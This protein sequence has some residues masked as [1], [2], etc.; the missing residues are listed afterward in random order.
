MALLSER[1]TLTQNLTY[2]AL[3]AAVNVVFSLLAAFFPFGALF[4]MI[5]LPAASAIVTYF[6]KPKF[7]VIYIV[8]AIA[9]SLLVT[10][11]DFQNTLFYT[12][13]AII[14]GSLY[15]FLKRIK[16]TTGENIFLCALLGVGF[17]YLAILLIQ[18]FYQ[19]DMIAFLLQMIGAKGDL[20]LLIVPAAIL[21]Y[22]LMQKSL[23]NLFIQVVSETFRIENKYTEI[24]EKLYPGF[25][26]FLFLLV[27]IFGFFFPEG[28][29]FCLV[30]GLYWT[31]FAI[32]FL[33]PRKTKWFYAIDG[34]LAV[35]GLILFYVFYLRLDVA[36]RLLLLALPFAGFALSAVLTNLWLLKKG[37]TSKMN[38]QGNDE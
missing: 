31:T 23:A 7:Y 10:L 38:P 15:G 5:F 6:C 11:W 8:G 22:N 9:L 3:M 16:L 36:T 34:G 24:H 33:Y 20:A 19:V 21:V 17:S 14:T 35:V 26:L 30:G 25:A 37:A 2:M 27:L 1:K 4:L 18:L 28:A 13:P 12:I 29:Y 32:A